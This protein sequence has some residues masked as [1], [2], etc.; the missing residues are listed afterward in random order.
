MT[1]HGSINER[2]AGV[3]LFAA[4]DRKHLQ[5]LASLVT[6]VDVAA[7]RELIHEGEVGHEFFIVVDGEAEVRIGDRVVARRGPGEYFGEIALLSNRPR[8]ATVTA[9]TAM[10]LQ[11]ISRREFQT[12]L[13]ENPA[14]ATELLAIAADRV[15]DSEAVH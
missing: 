13:Y 3:P 1:P 15:A 11:V 7:G 10:R 12:M 2:L 8:T 6:E 4:L 5:Q 9:L 14:I